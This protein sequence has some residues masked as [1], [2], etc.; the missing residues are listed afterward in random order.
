M[1][2]EL[3]KLVSVHVQ[4]SFIGS[5]HLGRLGLQIPNDPDCATP[6]G[7]LRRPND[8]D[9]ATPLGEVVWHNLSYWVLEDWVYLSFGLYGVAFRGVET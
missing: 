7:G 9:C 2:C 3:P 1:N 4:D 5:S 8:P 6:L